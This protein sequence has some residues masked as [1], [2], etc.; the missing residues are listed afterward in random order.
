MND[1]RRLLL[2]ESASVGEGYRSILKPRDLSRWDTE[3]LH[4]VFVAWDRA[5]GGPIYLDPEASMIY[6]VGVPNACM[7]Y[8]SMIYHAGVANACMRY[9]SMIYHAGVPNACMRYPFARDLSG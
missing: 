6:H 9:A 8:A 1:N 3:C 7:R 4:S 2:L 5:V